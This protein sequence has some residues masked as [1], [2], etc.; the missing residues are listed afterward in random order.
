MTTT[1]AL[2]PR[3]TIGILLAVIL[4]AVAS[5]IVTATSS[6]A[7]GFTHGITIDVDGEDYY[8]AGA[9]DGPDGAF[10]IPGHSWVK[11]GPDQLVGKHVNTGPF[12]AP[13]W[14]SSD[15]PDGAYLYNVHAIIDTWSEAKAADYA[16]RGY[17]HYHELISVDDST[18]HPDKVV[19]LKHTARTSFTLDGGP[20]PELSHEVTP[21]LDLGFVPNGMTPYNP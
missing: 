19:W 4:A 17:I 10:D 21:G 13:Q 2:H 8:L 18:P 1:T 14:W 12:G 9:P 5:V 20:H 15:A 11:A 6:E 3:R 16:E 7:A